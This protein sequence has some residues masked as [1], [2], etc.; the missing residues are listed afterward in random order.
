MK[1]KKKE[2]RDFI[3][4]LVVAG[5]LIYFTPYILKGQ[6]KPASQNQTEILNATKEN[7]SNLSTVNT[8]ENTSTVMK[9]NSKEENEKQEAENKTVNQSFK[10]F[11]GQDLRNE[12]P[13][14]YLINKHSRPYWMAEAKSM[15]PTILDND[16]IVATD[17]FNELKVGD[18]IWFK[19]N[20]K[21]I[22]PGLDFIFHRIIEIE[23]DG[24]LTKG[25]NNECVDPFLVKKDEV[26]FKIVGK[27]K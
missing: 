23:Q 6:S 11:D 8:G 3:L 1:S 27:L 15:W 22:Y 13:N 4:F 16:T 5:G 7:I 14:L 18:I 17:N 25:D 26:V 19:N 10:I 9:N 24:Y 20:H 2:I 21:D 12:P